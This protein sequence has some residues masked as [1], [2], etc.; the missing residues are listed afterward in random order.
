MFNS[1]WIYI[2]TLEKDNFADLTLFEH[3]ELDMGQVLV[4]ELISLVFIYFF[5]K[6]EISLFVWPGLI[7]NFFNKNV[8]L[9]IL[10]KIMET[11]FS[12]RPK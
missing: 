2:Y 1:A 12:S 11:G 5:S 6:I 8:A 7:F 4:L 9:S 10:N 3:S